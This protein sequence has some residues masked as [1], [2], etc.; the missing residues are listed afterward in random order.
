MK[1]PWE[2]QVVKQM[3]KRDDAEFTA[4]VS[5]QW[6]AL[7]RTA[8]LAIEQ[9]WFPET[10]GRLFRNCRHSSTPCTSTDPEANADSPWSAAAA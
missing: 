8:F 2:R 9:T 10:P 6:N 4:F 1:T 7:F 5:A 3:S